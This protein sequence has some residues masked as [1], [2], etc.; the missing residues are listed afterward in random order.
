MYM[1][2]DHSAST[3][4]SLISSKDCVI[5]PSRSQSQRTRSVMS[6]SHGPG[7]GGGGVGAVRVSVP[8]VVAPPAADPASAAA[9]DVG[10][11]TKK[12]PNS[13]SARMW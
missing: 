12:S 3:T 11:E 1:P 13:I 6:R 2:S 4:R 7:G 5:A 10:S 9:P 8:L